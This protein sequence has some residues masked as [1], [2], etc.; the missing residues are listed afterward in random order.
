MVPWS[1]RQTSELVLVVLALHRVLY[2]IRG[3]IT[4]L[5]NGKTACHTTGRQTASRS[6]AVTRYVWRQYAGSADRDTKRL[7]PVCPC[8][9]QCFG[10]RH[11]VASM[12]PRQTSN[13][14][15]Y[16]MICQEGLCER[17]DMVRGGRKLSRLVVEVTGPRMME[18]KKS[19]PSSTSNSR[20]QVVDLRHPQQ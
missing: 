7:T 8:L 4:K 3:C 18:A 20:L 15:P 19:V 6:F 17:L 14:E 9:N 11:G 5:G 13:S 1:E 12:I 2:L 10:V 16:P